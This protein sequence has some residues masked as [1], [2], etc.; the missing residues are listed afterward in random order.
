[1]RKLFL[2]F[3][4]V[5]MSA[6]AQTATVTVTTYQA[7]VSQCD[8]DPFTT[9]DGT[10]IVPKKVK[11]GSQKIV[12]VSRNLL[13]HFPYGSTVHIEGFGYYKVH[14]TMNKRYTN[15]VDILIPNDQKGTKKTNVKITKVG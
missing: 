3:A 8:S 10:K 1:M 4:I 7:K 13:K 12:A 11:N 14:D 9:A 2:L 6:S 15:Y 5:A